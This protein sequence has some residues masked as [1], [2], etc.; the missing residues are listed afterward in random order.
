MEQ[1][2]RTLI[3]IVDGDLDLHTAPAARQA[4]DAAL[5][6]RPR[7]LIVD[8][9]L[10]PFLNSTGLEVLLAAHRQAAPHTD[11]RLVVTTRAVSR[12]LQ[13]ARPHERLIIHGSRSAAIVTPA[14]TDDDVPSTQPRPD[15]QP[16]SPPAEVP[17]KGDARNDHGQAS[18]RSRHPHR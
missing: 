8:L 16:A 7:R 10:V 14:G 1:L 3:L 6:R 4:I 5:S 9:S 18:N 11:F 2:G 12:L 13:I 17:A 15:H